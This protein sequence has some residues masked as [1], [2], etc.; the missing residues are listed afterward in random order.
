MLWDKED[1]MG[2]DL[3][4]GRK[5]GKGSGLSIRRRLKNQR[6]LRNR[7]ENK[8]HSSCG[9]RRVSGRVGGDKGEEHQMRCSGWQGWLPHFGGLSAQ[10][11]SQREGW[12]Q[13]ADRETS[14]QVMGGGL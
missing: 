1:G 3:E 13:G 2:S 11:E 10:W 9:L 7:E 6:D 4:G 8:S 12:R 5:E 14:Q